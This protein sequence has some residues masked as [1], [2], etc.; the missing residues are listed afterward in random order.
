M[1]GTE[2]RA[3]VGASP[4]EGIVGSRVR[5]VL[6]RAALTLTGGLSV[7]G[8][9][10]EGGCVV[11]ANHSSHADTAALLA[12]LPADSRPVF[13]AAADYWG[14]SPLRRWA[15]RSLGGGFE[16]RRGGG[17]SADLAPLVEQLRAGR[18]V[19]IF[20]EG[21]R[22]RDGS[23]GEF[24]SGAFRLAERAGVPVVPV[25]LRGT[26]DLLPVHGDVHRAA[27]QVRIGAPIEHATPDAA[28]SAVEALKAEPMSR[29]DSALRQRVA[30]F[31]RTRACLALVFVWAFSEAIAWPI[32]PEVLLVVLV[33]AA[34]LQ[35]WRWVA[36]ALVA[37]VLGGVVMLS[38][39]GAGVRPPQPLV[40]DD[41]RATASAEVAASGATAVYGQPL[42]GVPY[43]VYATAAGEQNLNAVEFAA[44]SA[45]ARGT[46]FFLIAGLAAF[47]AV[48]SRR[49]RRFYPAVVFILLLGFTV[50]LTNVVTGFTS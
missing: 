50:G 10:P 43:K 41:M 47:V 13:V 8:S 1:S 26:S 2:V 34:P 5:R 17:G 11:V 12:S 31:S 16:V 18:T 7:Q 20:A 22:S 25:G 27:V 21:T 15:C 3:S 14:S 35:W 32:V 48:A 9:L 44:H 42:S 28:R 49:W 4:S 29:P 24:R 36:T 33:L 46:R 23:V 40:T 39:A 6:W 38:L 45:V 19:V 37:G 30:S